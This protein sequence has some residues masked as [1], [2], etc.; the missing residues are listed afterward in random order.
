M[1]IYLM[2]EAG[3]PRVL[4]FEPD[5]GGISEDQDPEAIAAA[6]E[7]EDVRAMDEGVLATWSRDTGCWLTN[8]HPVEPYLGEALTEHAKS[9]GTRWD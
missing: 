1:N 8:G 5:Y 3:P 9:L 7:A 2:P 4:L 6:V